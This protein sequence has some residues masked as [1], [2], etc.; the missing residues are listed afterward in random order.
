MARYE[1][2][3]ISA[4]V[5]RTRTTE[6]VAHLNRHRPWKSKRRGAEVIGAGR[7]YLILLYDPE[8]KQVKRGSGPRAHSLTLVGRGTTYGTV[9]QEQGRQGNVEKCTR[10]T[11]RFS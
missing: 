7:I 10:G 11:V 3:F 4:P 8:R 6:K 5:G 2:V 9:I 1:K